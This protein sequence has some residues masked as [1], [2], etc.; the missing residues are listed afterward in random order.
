MSGH[1]TMS[2]PQIDRLTLEVPPMS[3]ADGQRLGLLVATGLARAAHG[4]GGTV[5]I[6][7][8]RVAVAPGRPGGLEALADHIVADALRQIRRTP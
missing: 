7:S 5:D 4:V 8:I 3:A 1:D 2:G 6:A